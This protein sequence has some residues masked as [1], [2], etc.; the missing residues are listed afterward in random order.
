MKYDFIA[1]GGIVE[2]ITF[3]T[4]E[5]VLVDNKADIL[6]QKLIG[7]EYGA[8][9]RVDDVSRFPG[10]GANNAAVCLSR[11]G[12]KTALL[13]MVGED[14]VGKKMVKNLVDNNVDTRLV[15]ILKG[16]ETGFTFVVVNKDREHVM[17][18][19]RA[20]N[21]LLQLTKIE[22]HMLSYAK[23]LYVASLSG[24]WEKVLDK[25]FSVKDVLIAWNPGG[26]QLA[27]GA[28]KLQK[29]I[30]KT[31]VFMVNK[32]EAIELAVSL[33]KNKN[34]P[35]N[36]YN[37][38]KNLLMLLKE[39]GPDA[40]LITDGGNGADFYDGEEFHHENS[41]RVPLKQISDTTGVGDSFCSTFI[42]GLEMYEGNHKKAM[43]L[44]MKNSAANLKEMGAQ[45]GLIS[46]KR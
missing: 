8:K 7:F 32:D 34:Q 5:G 24:D 21:S 41:L 11:L 10:G 14:E 20:A 23:W 28:L 16:G 26:A 15:R 6:K 27:A 12:F 9:I 30:K 2:D 44:A 22:A 46:I 31:A 38:T 42:A 4:D 37:D 17:F 13:A 19:Y 35:K 33:G 36:F 40:V 25:V 1:I 18:V 3:Y 45:E 43:K 39:L 29:Y